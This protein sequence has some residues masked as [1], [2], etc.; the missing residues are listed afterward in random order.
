MLRDLYRATRPDN[1]V[2]AALLT[3]DRASLDAAMAAMPDGLDRARSERADLLLQAAAQARREAVSL[4]LEHDF[5]FALADG[6]SALQT[7][8]V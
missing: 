8:R 4:L 5:P 1:P 3:G 2:V 6:T 7:L